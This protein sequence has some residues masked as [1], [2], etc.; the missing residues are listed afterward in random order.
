MLFFF[1]SRR[2]H[3]RCALVTGVQ[4]CALPILM[5]VGINDFNA[6]DDWIHYFIGQDKFVLVT[7]LHGTN[8][9]VLISD[10]GKA[11]KSSL[12]ETRE[13]FQ[14]YVSA[15]DDVAAL[16]EPRWATKWRVWK[17]MTSSYPQGAVFLAGDGANC[18]SPSCGRV[19][20][21]RM[22][23]TFNLSWHIAMSQNV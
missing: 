20:T 18:H 9:R 17:R 13:A 7:K 3:T 15:F 14:G 21:L 22:Q 1:S 5:D 11:D 4:T 10:N 8:Y 6:G 19:L 23:V 16:D 12:E 2:R